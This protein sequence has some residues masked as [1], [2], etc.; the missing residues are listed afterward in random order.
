[1]SFLQLFRKVCVVNLAA[2]VL[3]LPAVLYY[4]ERFPFISLY[5]NLFMPF[6]VALLLV[7]GLVVP[8]HA[9]VGKL[10]CWVLK[11]LHAFVVAYDVRLE[12]GLSSGCAVL[13]TLGLVVI[14]VSQWK[15]SKKNVPFQG[16]PWQKRLPTSVTHGIGLVLSLAGLGALI[17]ASFYFSSKVLVAASVVFGTSL[18]MLY[19]ASTV[20]HAVR[21]EPSKKIFRILDHACIYL[22]IAGTYTPYTLGP[23]WGPWG[24]TIFAIIWGCAIAG[25]LMKS[26]RFRNGGVLSTLFYLI[27]GWMCMIAII[28]LFKNLP[29][30]S[31]ALLLV[32]GVFYSLGTIFYAIKRLRFSHAIWHLFVLG[33]SISHYVSIFVYIVS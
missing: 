17:V 16:K 28:P 8:L 14:G 12:V 21:H 3:C 9:W 20:Y 31:F 5:Y 27:M 1:M 33:G 25:I 11:W 13:L 19:G 7:G 24:W 4:F 15:S 30:T 10:S 29:T 18:V 22:L 26:F 23:L 32:G 2:N 6:V